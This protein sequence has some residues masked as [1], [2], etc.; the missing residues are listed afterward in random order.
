MI[1]ANELN[2]VRIFYLRTSTGNMQAA[3]VIDGRHYSSSEDVRRAIAEA[4]EHLDARR[5]VAEFETREIESSLALPR[6]PSWQAYKRQL[7]PLE[8]KIYD[9][10]TT[11]K[12]AKNHLEEVFPQETLNT[13]E[14]A[15]T[16]AL[17]CHKEQQRPDGEPYMKHLLEVS[18]ILVGGVGI[19]NETVILAGIL[20]DVVE[21]TKCSLDEIR[22]RFGAEVANLVAWLTEQ[23]QAGLGTDRERREKYFDQL[24]S[25]PLDAIVVKLADRLSNVQKLNTHPNPEKQK[26]YYLETV[27]KV[28]PLA[29]RHPWFALQFELWRE[30]FEPM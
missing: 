9:N 13:L 11:W 1:Q 10:W 8:P 28:I 14:S 25:A 22:F 23:G 16:F 15:F 19:A 7:P 30:K 24:Q 21:D 3:F 29:N 2:K 20:H 4:G 26:M 5:I 27:E 17:N 6:L 12:E 18:E